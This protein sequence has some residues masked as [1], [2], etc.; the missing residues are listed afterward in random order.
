MDWPASAPPPLLTEGLLPINLAQHLSVS[1]EQKDSFFGG[2]T[3]G[4][5]RRVSIV[6]WET[7]WLEGVGFGGGE[8]LAGRGEAVFHALSGTHSTESTVRHGVLWAGL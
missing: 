7:M 1:F 4:E 2:G 8:H 6:S 5:A 3:G